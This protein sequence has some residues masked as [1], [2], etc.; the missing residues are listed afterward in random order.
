MSVLA[1]PASPLGTRRAA[2]ER[3]SV[4]FRHTRA[5]AQ[6]ATLKLELVTDRQA[7]DA[8]EQEWTD[9]FERS[10]R[11]SQLFQGHRWLWHWCNHFL[12]A[13]QSTSSLAIVT[14]RRDGRLVI[15][16]PLVRTTSMG[17]AHL[18]FMGDPVSQYGDVLVE[19]GPQ[20][21][22]DVRAAWTFALRSTNVDFVSLRK[23]RADASIAPVLAESSAIITERQV[24]PY[25]AFEG[26]TDFSKFETR[27]SK[28][29]RRNRKRQLRRLQDLGETTFERLGPGEAARDAV[30]LAISM[31]RGWLKDRGLVSAAITDARTEAFFRDCAAG[32]RKDTSLEVGLIRTNGEV[33][34]VELALSCQDRVAVHVIAYNL[35]FEKTGAGGLLMQDSIRRACENGQEVLD[36][37]APGSS[38]KFDWTDRA[39]DVND[40]AVGL[41]AAG[42]LYASVYLKRLRP[43]A[44]QAVEQMPAALRRHVSTV[45]SALLIIGN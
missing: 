14:G 39:I 34:A 4:A 19:A 5:E 3:A 37:L 33:A 36:L 7:F 9:L 15:V 43:A 10:G 40:Y 25:V 29:S 11:S 23:V 31:K 44:K 35:K 16:S 28:A 20:A 8:L 18:S 13:D 6:A 27:Y 12:P 30:S 32:E 21:Q 26:E 38:Y 24:A 45:L 22:A 1:I 42:R 17:L 2:A 41:T